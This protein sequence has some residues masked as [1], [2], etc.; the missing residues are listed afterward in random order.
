MTDNNILDT[1][2][3]RDMRETASLVNGLDA[4]AGMVGL[5]LVTP[6][7]IP[8]EKTLVNRLTRHLNRV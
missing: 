7:S 4:L 8:L 2:T 1:D 6:V 5:A 3:M